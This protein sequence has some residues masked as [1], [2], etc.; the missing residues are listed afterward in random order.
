M[1]VLH[2]TCSDRSCWP[3]S[4]GQVLLLF[5]SAHL[6]GGPFSLSLTTSGEIRGERN[7]VRRGFGDSNPLLPP[8][9]VERI[10]SR[11]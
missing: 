7:L 4:L 5:V 10:L 2:L 6:H 3:P 11:K 8:L 9:L 1:K